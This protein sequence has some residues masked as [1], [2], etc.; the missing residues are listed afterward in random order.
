MVLKKLA[1]WRKEQQS[2]GGV[3]GSSRYSPPLSAIHG[4]FAA[5]I[6]HSLQ[7]SWSC[8]SHSAA[9]S[10]HTRAHSS[11][12][13]RQHLIVRSRPPQPQI[14]R[15]VANVGAVEAHPDA[16][17]HVHV[18]GRAGVGAAQAHLRA[19]HRVMDGIAERLV[20]VPGDLGVKADHLANGHDSPYVPINLW[21]GATIL[22]SKDNNSALKSLFCSGE[23]KCVVEATVIIVGVI[24]L[25]LGSAVIGWLFGQSWRARAPGRRSIYSP[26]RSSTKW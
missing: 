3:D 17:A 15:R 24:A 14:G 7:C 13:S 4:A 25:A 1:K 21:T 11:S 23:G 20:D 16:L 26:S 8:F 12:I 9:H 6:A 10:S 22:L 2:K 5:H 19:I 18:L